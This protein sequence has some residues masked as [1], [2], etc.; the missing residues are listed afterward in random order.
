MSQDVWKNPVAWSHL[1]AFQVY[2]Q[3]F[4]INYSKK[5]WSFQ[6]CVS[7][8]KH[9]SKDLK[10]LYVHCS[11]GFNLDFMRVSNCNDILWKDTTPNTVLLPSCFFTPFMTNILDS[12]FF[13]KRSS[14][15]NS[16]LYN[17]FFC[18]LP[19]ILIRRI[20]HLWVYCRK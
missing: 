9:V 5:L 4:S 2:P 17:C 6:N 12:W 13:L 11:S 10:A 20:L 1:L 15:L 3:F 14:H 8:F 19:R 16:L 18:L 7:A